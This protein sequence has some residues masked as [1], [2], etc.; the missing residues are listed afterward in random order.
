MPM[1]E[2]VS[3]MPM[4]S[5]DDGTVKELLTSSKTKEALREAKTFFP[6]FLLQNFHYQ[7]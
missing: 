6:L 3:S 1:P 5:Y 4:P 2:L 7:E